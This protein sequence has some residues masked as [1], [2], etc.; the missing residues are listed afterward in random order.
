MNDLRAKLQAQS[1]QKTAPAVL[2][3]VVDDAVDGQRLDN[4]LISQLKG[5]PKSRIY[6]MVR[7]G[8]V[9]IDKGR[10]KI[11]QRLQLGQT[12][13]I[14]PVRVDA[15]A[16]KP[17]APP[18]S[19]EQL[20]ILY[21]DDELIAVDKPVGLAVHGGSGVA[22][23]VIERLR[24]ARPQARFLELVHR[25]DRE[26]SGVL[27]VAKKRPALVYLHEQLR[28]RK[29]TK[30]YYA[31]VAGGWPS[32][33]KRLDF[34]L[35]KTTNHAGERH[36]YADSQGIEAVTLVRCLQQVHGPLGAFSLVE[37]RL[38]TGRTHQIRVHL[39]H[40]GFPIV[41]DPK[42]GHFDLN[43]LLNKYGHK[44]MFLHA[45]MFAF[46]GKNEKLLEVK[47]DLPITF[48]AFLA[49]PKIADGCESLE[50]RSNV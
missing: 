18:I 42:Y 23:G 25:L 17:V 40:A 33:L 36:V 7:D 29:T 38:E 9:R 24:A 21:E 43:K 26:T 27:L 48:S 3:V 15:T 5:V 50:F 46:V 12:V 4:F 8:E 10:A 37:C 2:F 34:S 44:R 49:E 28:A 13:R 45:F 14:P 6:R 20:P 11:D 41:G 19:L 1:D 30:R 31:I 47:T 16:V 22:H 32:H 39:A 35:I